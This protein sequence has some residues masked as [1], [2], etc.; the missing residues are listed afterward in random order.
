MKVLL[1]A[2][3]KLEVYR[4]YL[5]EVGPEIFP[6]FC[7]GKFCNVF[8]KFRLTVSPGEIGIG[9]GETYLPQ[10]FH[11]PWPGKSFSKKNNAI[12]LFDLY[13]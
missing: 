7:F 8:Y 6:H 2:P 12:I 3:M 4:E 11:D 9:L 1:Y 5:A 13:R 10:F